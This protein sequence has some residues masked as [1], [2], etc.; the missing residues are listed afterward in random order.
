MKKI[1]TPKHDLELAQWKTRLDNAGIDYEDVLNQKS[2]PSLLLEEQAIVI[3]IDPVPTEVPQ[4]PQVN[5]KPKS[6]WQNPNKEYFGYAALLFIIIVG[7][8]LGQPLKKDETITDSAGQSNNVLASD[9]D[10]KLVTDPKELA[11]FDSLEILK[12]NA[13]LLHKIELETASASKFNGKNFRGSPESIGLEIRVFSEWTRLVAEGENT[14]NTKVVAAAKKLKKAASAAQVREFPKMRKHIA[15]LLASALWENN[16]EVKPKGKG[17][18]T[19]EYTGIIF[20]NNKTIKE[21][22][23][24]LEDTLVSLRFN[25]VNY[26]WSKYADEYTTIKL[27]AIPDNELVFAR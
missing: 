5:Q 15:E 4:N 23:E 3:L 22:Y 11:R 19:L 16:I 24:S 1:I 12:K 26:V 27:E 18:R 7:L 9:P 17:Y 6:F 10:I 14:K 21:M 25:R 13:F 20:A 8:I 2:E